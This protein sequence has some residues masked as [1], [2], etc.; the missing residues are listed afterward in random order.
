MEKTFQKFSCNNAKD[1]ATAL[2]TLQKELSEVKKEITY[3]DVYNIVEVCE[4]KNT[5]SAKAN[6]LAPNSAMV[7][8]TEPFFYNEKVYNTGD[9]VLKLATEEIV[10]IKAQTGG[11]FY[12]NKIV[13]DKTA[14]TYNISFAFS[15]TEPVTETATTNVNTEAPLAKT[16]TF[17]GLADSESNTNVYGIWGSFEDNSEFSYNN[18]PPYV[19]FYYKSDNDMEEVILDHSIEISGQSVAIYIDDDVIIENTEDKKSNMLYIKVK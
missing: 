17:T 4:D 16:I 5:F 18:C 14:G 7:I 19:K 11:I 12:P 1:Y 13:K 9:I 8:N 2:N 10:H 15:G 3:L 6:S